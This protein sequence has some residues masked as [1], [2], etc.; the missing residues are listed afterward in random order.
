M[1]Q[2]LGFRISIKP[3]AILREHEIKIASLDYK[4][5]LMAMSV[6]LGY[7]SL[8]QEA[9]PSCDTDSFVSERIFHSTSDIR[10]IASHCSPAAPGR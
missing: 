3:F 5:V 6:E 10:S 9:A 4:Y 7:N 2:Y 1:D 8:A